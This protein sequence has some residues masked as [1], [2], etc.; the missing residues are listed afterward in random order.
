MS[1][2]AYAQSIGDKFIEVRGYGFALSP[3]DLQ[4]IDKWE[5][6]GVPLFIPM[7]VIADIEERF[8]V[9]G[10]RSQVRIRGLSYIEEEVE[11]RFSELVAGH[12]GCGGCEK[13][14]CAARRTE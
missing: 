5:S 11:A 13:S 14:Y 9:S 12:V 3:F 2:S 8:Q 7:N 1:E 4:L 10:S 6:R